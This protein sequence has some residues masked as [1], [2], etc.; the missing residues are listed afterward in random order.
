MGQAVKVKIISVN[1]P[2]RQLNLVP[3]K[4]FATSATEKRKDR[5]AKKSKKEKYRK[6]HR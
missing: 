4:P 6:N 2:A 3:V 1:V 5:K